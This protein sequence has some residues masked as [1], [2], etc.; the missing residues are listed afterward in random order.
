MKFIQV[1]NFK[2]RLNFSIYE[3]S[4]KALK[5]IIYNQKLSLSI[6]WKAM[7]LLSQISSFS[8]TKIN[9]RCFKT[10]RRKGFI[11][12]SGLSRIQMRNLGRDGK[13]PF[14]KKASW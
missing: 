9:N 10:G 12:F 11:R 6:R 7:L 2:N 3:S 5:F 14:I 4:F 13:L 8:K 1:K